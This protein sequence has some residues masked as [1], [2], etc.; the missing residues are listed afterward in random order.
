M[1]IMHR[2]LEAEGKRV[3][4]LG[5]EAIVRGALESGVGFVS[6]YP[7]TPSSEI[8]DTF[9]DVAKDAGIYFEWSTNEKVAVE[10]AAGAAFSGVRSL[11]AFKHF[12]F[13]VASDS[14]YP[15]AYY[16]VRA[17]MVII[18][19][20]DPGCWSSGQS[21]QD[22]RLYARIAHLPM[23]EPADHVE[24][25][26]FTKL[27][28]EISEKF[29]I[30]VIVRTTTRVAHASGIVQL[31]KIVKGPTKGQ[32][33]KGNK[34]RTMPP[35]ML[36][37][38]TELHGKLDQIKSWIENKNLDFS[39]NEKSSKEL[40]VV[41]SGVSYC[42]VMEALEKLNIKLP[43]LKIGMSWPLQD[44]KIKDFIKDLAC[45]LVVEELEP[46]LE[47]EVQR[48]AKEANPK[49]I[50]KGKDCL[51]LACEIKPETVVC[52]IAK[53]LGREKELLVAQAASLKKLVTLKIP[54][55][56]PTLCPGCPH[57]ATFYAAK[58]AAG[59]NAVF[60]GDIGCYILGVYPPLE[61]SDLI[62]SMGAGEG[63]AHGVKKVSDQ[64]VIAFIGDSTFF[65]AGIP[66]LIN[67]TYN[68]SNPL[69]IALDNR[70]TAMTGHQPH[71][72]MG[73]TGMGE[74]TKELKIDEIAKACGIE[75]ISG[76]N[77]FSVKETTDKIK[78]FLTKQTA[79]LIVAHG[80]CRLQFMRKA[81]KQG[82]KIPVFEIDTKKCNKCTICVYKFGCPAIHHDLE[83]DLYYIDPDMCWGCG[84][85]PQI[86][87]ARAIVPRLEKK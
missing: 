29:K 34:W 2:V 71:P 58:M 16:T 62:F 65:H 18:N 47:Q 49:L 52:A 60:S 36:R 69:V 80:E 43:V 77:C 15:L 84:V 13:N 31:G 87:P 73:V 51:P 20:D 17:G 5:N 67:M 55:R 45:V 53:S 75:N 24:C 46:I 63:I 30:P 85:C 35:E 3:I 74:P 83:K 82:I 68:K 22:N 64:K 4:L 48:I 57:R 32:F 14:I 76:V 38:H 66:A 11:V 12:G 59:E 37:I 39:V 28:F 40:G 19:A 61:T 27:A 86:C 33:V 6:Q 54:P 23:L 9:S 26:D 70:W 41:T 21:E 78:E 81:R 42:Y 25:R 8:G 72:G 56:P 10:A 50:I 79:S 44:K 7:G 1:I